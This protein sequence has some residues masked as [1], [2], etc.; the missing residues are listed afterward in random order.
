MAEPLSLER[1]AGDVGY[2]ANYLND[3]TRLHTGR[4]LGGWIAE[5][6]MFRART[7]LEQT[8]LPVADIGV[9]CGYDDPAYFSRFF[10]VDEISDEVS[11]VTT[12][13]I[14]LLAQQLLDPAKLALT[15]LGPLSGLKIDRSQLNC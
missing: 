5:M 14:Q 9:M 2:T 1:L 11:A 12:E 8:D 15:L 7:A 3:L 10:T 13:E 6:R 4:P